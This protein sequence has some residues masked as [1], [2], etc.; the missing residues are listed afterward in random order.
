MERPVDQ[1]PLRMKRIED[2]FASKGIKVKVE[3]HGDYYQVLHFV[4]L[5]IEI[6]ANGDKWDGGWFSIVGDSI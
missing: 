6:R 4:D 2:L 1:N 5:G 3:D